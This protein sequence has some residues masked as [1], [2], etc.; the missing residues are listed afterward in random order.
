MFTAGHRKLSCESRLHDKSKCFSFKSKNTSSFIVVSELL[1]I[2]IASSRLIALNVWSGRKVIWLL[3]RSRFFKWEKSLNISPS[4]YF[5]KLWLT[6][7]TWE[8][9]SWQEFTILIRLNVS[10]LHRVSSHINWHTLLIFWK[11]VSLRMA[12]LEWKFTMNTSEAYLPQA[13]L[14]LWM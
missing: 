13:L 10:L 6:L 5:I 11:F 2:F 8:V 4:M 7:R 1:F 3:L 14:S 12:S 9:I